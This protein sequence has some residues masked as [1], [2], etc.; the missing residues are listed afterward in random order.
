MIEENDGLKIVAHSHATAIQVED[1]RH[2]PVRVGVKA[3]PDS[4][5]REVVSVERG[6]H[7]DGA[8]I[9]DCDCPSLSLGADDWPTRVI[10]IEGFTM[11]EIAH[12]RLPSVRRQGIQARTAAGL[13]SGTGWRVCS[14]CVRRPRR[15]VSGPGLRTEEEEQR[16]PLREG[17]T[18]QSAA[19]QIR[20]IVVSL[21]LFP[22]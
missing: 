5:A 16:W 15:T 17:H 8:A 7:G 20:S 1:L 14:Q 13:P 9:P 4:G 21:R 19:R 18:W 22:S 2:G 3:E 12:M 6:R 10:Q 11:C